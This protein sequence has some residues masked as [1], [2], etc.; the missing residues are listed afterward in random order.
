MNTIK[1]KNRFIRISGYLTL[2]LGVIHSAATPLVMKSYSFS[3]DDLKLT[4]L[5]MFVSTGVAVL[6]TS[7]LL[8]YSIKL[9]KDSLKHSNVIIAVAASLTLFIGSISIV[10][11]PSNPFAYL[12]LIA[13]TF[14]ILGLRK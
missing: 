4:F 7:I 3:N 14:G 9:R 13:G 1:L 11:M 5:N 10:L 2:S 12:T 8:L 6:I